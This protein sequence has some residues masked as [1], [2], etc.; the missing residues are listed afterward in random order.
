MFAP[1]IAAALI[2]ALSQGPAAST[3]NASRA[4]NG[5][6]ESAARIRAEVVDSLRDPPSAYFRTVEVVRP[7]GAGEGAR[8]ICG[9]VQ[10]RN[11]YGGMAQAQLFFYTD[12]VSL[13]PNSPMSAPLW[14]S[15]CRGGEVLETLNWNASQ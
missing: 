11:G 2:G 5:T 1:L 12:S 8:I 9:S 14:S 10:G 4:Y 15:L 13:L 7:D 3:Y 6:A